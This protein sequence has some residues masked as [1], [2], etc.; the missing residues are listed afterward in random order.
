MERHLSEDAGKGSDV[1]L[2]E[3]AIENQGAYDAST[4][5]G[6]SLI[7]QRPTFAA[8]LSSPL[9]PTLRPR[10]D[11]SRG[12]GRYRHPPTVELAR[13]GA[14]DGTGSTLGFIREHRADEV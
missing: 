11:S 5:R 1:V 13:S 3:E 2:G 12:T 8:A 7:P 10:A 4:M 14:P 9:H 6:L